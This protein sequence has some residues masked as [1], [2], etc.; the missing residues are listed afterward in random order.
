MVDLG[1]VNFSELAISKFCYC[2]YV[3]YKFQFE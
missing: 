2:E 1:G 3:V